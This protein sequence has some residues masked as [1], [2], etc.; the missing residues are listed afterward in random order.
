MADARRIRRAE[1][2]RIA[3]DARAQ[4]Q[5]GGVRK[6]LVWFEEIGV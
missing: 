1:A 5:G 6:E 2:A 3:T 4:P